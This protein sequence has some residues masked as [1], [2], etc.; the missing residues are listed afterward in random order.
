MLVNQILKKFKLT[1]STKLYDTNYFKS[2]FLNFNSFTVFYLFK[3][4]KVSGISCTFLPKNLKKRKNLKK[5]QK[6]KT[7][8]KLNITALFIKKNIL[9]KYVL[10]KKVNFKIFQFLPILSIIDLV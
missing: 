5:L 6:F 9:F 7:T 2:Y 3:F 1:K 10:L 4:L 8:Q